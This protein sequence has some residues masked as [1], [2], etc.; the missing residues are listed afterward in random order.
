VWQFWDIS[1][2]GLIPKKVAAVAGTKAV[3][4]DSDSPAGIKAL[5]SSSGR[6]GQSRPTGPGASRRDSDYL[7]R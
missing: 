5:L 1:G 4:L 2:L 6:N 3:P 7:L